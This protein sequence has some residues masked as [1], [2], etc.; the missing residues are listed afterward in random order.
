MSFVENIHFSCQIYV[1]ICNEH[2]SDITV[3]CI[4]FE[5]DVTTEQYHM[6]K[7]NFV[8]FEFKMRFERI[9]YIAQPQQIT[10]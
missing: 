6:G 5:I 2:D 8:K 4:T 1:Q 3:L 7:Q 10:N 9:S